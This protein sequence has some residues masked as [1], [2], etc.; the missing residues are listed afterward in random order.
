MVPPSNHKER[1]VG[2]RA[3]WR[4]ASQLLC[5]RMLGH[6]LVIAG[7]SNCVSV[8]LQRRR[9]NWPRATALLDMPTGYCCELLYSLHFTVPCSSLSNNNN[10][11]HDNVYGAVI[12]TKVIARVHPVHLMNAD[13]AP[14]GRQHSDQASRFGLWVHRKLA[15]VIHIH[16]RH[17]YYYS[18]LILPSHEGWKACMRQHICS[19]R[20]NKSSLHS[21]YS[22]WRNY[23]WP[24]AIDYGP[25]SS[26]RCLKI[27]PRVFNLHD[28][29]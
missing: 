18:R 27:V 13:W 7:V 23:L 28:T 2:Q 11:S 5:F 14:G 12:M 16:H 22:Y 19:E 24:H 4:R 6:G 8:S 26:K 10:N 15:A 21:A 17:C 1:Q 29:F 20:S 25:N 3:C 9:L